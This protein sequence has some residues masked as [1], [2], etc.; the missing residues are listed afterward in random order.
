MQIRVLAMAVLVSI[1]FAAQAWPVE[2]H[3]DYN[4]GSTITITNAAGDQEHPAI[5][6]NPVLKQ[7]LVV[8]QT[9][10]YGDWDIVARLYDT[11]GR[12][13]GPDLYPG[14]S[15]ADAKF[16]VVAANWNVGAY[17][18]VWQQY[19]TLIIPNRWEIYGQ[20]MPWNDPYANSAFL[21]ASWSENHMQ[22]P[23]V[24]W[25]SYRNRFMVVW[26][27]SLISSNALQA[28][29]RRGINANGT[30]FTTAADIIAGAVNQGF[31][32][33]TYNVAMDEYLVVWARG[34]S[35]SNVDIRGHRLNKDGGLSGSLIYIASGTTFDQNPAVTTNE[36]DQYLVVWEKQILGTPDFY[37]ICG[38]LLNVLGQAL[39]GEMG[40]GGAPFWTII[41]GWE[42]GNSTKP[43][44][45]ANGGIGDYLT[46]HQQEALAGD[47][48]YGTTYEPASNPANM[49]RVVHFVPNLV[50]GGFGNNANV[51]AAFHP[52]GYFIVYD[53]EPFDPTG[54]KDV[55][56][57][58]IT[59]KEEDDLLLMLV[60]V[61]GGL[62]KK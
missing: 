25:N 47:I 42:L 32:D 30:F 56:G 27:R 9:D 43:D 34:L 3:P 40:L 14:L 59:L 38:I 51:A 35:A 28:I 11:A 60:P 41:N 20:I 50:P 31:P 8:W 44:V 22:Y 21:I 12:A 37:H 46:V 16:P 18:I 5:C 33:I 36:Q 2:Q 49:D 19:N 7:Y 55:Y 29:G 15:T 10:E 6:Y 62:K 39:R 48:I 52:R 57:C 61:L 23:A 58:L 26:Q 54:T 13:L 4:V 45:Q 17:L 1:F 53:W 24:A